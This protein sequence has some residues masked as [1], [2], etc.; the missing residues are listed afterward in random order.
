[1]S[2]GFDQR[3]E[4][5]DDVSMN[6]LKGEAVLLNLV[7]ETYYGLDEVGTSM[8]IRLRD[9]DSIQDAYESLLAEYEVDPE[10]LRRDLEELIE[11]LAA[12]GLVKLGSA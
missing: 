1:M 6:V 3:V 11:K 8:W 12:R 4:I 7:D 2:V 5:P 9:S 10:V